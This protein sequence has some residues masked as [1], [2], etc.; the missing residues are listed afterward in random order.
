[1]A[2]R[3]VPASAAASAA[4]VTSETASASELCTR[5]IDA[6]SLG[7]GAWPLARSLASCQPAAGPAAIG[8][9]A[10]GRSLPAS[11]SPPASCLPPPPPLGD[12]MASATAAVAVPSGLVAPSASGSA[13]GEA[14]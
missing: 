3:A 9:V 8:W 13:A 4:P 11:R 6:D 10:A 7:C 14:A 12:C 1:M 2:A 5:V